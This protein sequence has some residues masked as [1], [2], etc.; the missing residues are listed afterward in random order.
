MKKDSHA[1]TL[2]KTISWRFIATGTT[3]VAAYILTGEITTALGIGG[4]E[5][6]AKLIFYYLHE[7]AW[8]NVKWGKGIL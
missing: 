5:A 4:I 7:R 2:T 8:A 1:R 6:T 3:I